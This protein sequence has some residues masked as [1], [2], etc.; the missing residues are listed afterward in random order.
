MQVCPCCGLPCIPLAP[1]VIRGPLPWPPSLHSPDVD[2]PGARPHAHP[3]NEAPLHQLVGL[4]AHDLTVLARP[5]LAL[6]AVDHQVAGPAITH[7]GGCVG[8]G[9]GRELRGGQPCVSG[10]RMLEPGGGGGML[11]PS[12]CPQAPA[13]AKKRGTFPF[14]ASRPPAV[15]PACLHSCRSAVSRSP[16]CCCCLHCPSHLTTPIPL[17]AA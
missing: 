11:C 3:G 12:Q 2:V 17:A 8:G 9:G 6:V 7:L 10:C 5:R 13:T 15:Q 14:Q 16:C 4:V 1:D